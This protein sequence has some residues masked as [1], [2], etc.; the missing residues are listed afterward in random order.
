MK[1]TVN[2]IETVEHAIEIIAS[3]VMAGTWHSPLCPKTIEALR[4]RGVSEKHLESFNPS[5]M[6]GHRILNPL[7]NA[8]IHL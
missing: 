2:T 4:A 5:F 8:P 6:T 3:R 7:L 1:V